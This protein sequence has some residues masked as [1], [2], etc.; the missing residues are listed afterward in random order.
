MVGAPDVVCLP[1]VKKIST[2]LLSEKY[3]YSDLMTLPWEVVGAVAIHKFMRGEWPPERQS[4][5]LYAS[6]KQ[7]RAGGAKNSSN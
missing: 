7:D 5:G 2:E 3:D 4:G 1:T 6:K